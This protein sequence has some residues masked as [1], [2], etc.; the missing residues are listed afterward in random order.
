MWT[1]KESNSGA[2]ACRDM[3]RSLFGKPRAASARNQ[4]EFNLEDQK[5]A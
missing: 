5:A 4:A 1:I 3:S 2:D